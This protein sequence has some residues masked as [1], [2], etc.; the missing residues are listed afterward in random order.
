MKA[1]LVVASAQSSEIKTLMATA[2]SAGS[3][4]GL[5]ANYLTVVTPIIDKRTIAGRAN[6]YGVF[7]TLLFNPDNLEFVKTGTISIAA[8]QKTAN[9]CE[10]EDLPEECTIEMIRK[11]PTV[12]IIAGSSRTNGKSAYE[13]VK[14]W[15]EGKQIIAKLEQKRVV[16]IAFTTE[17]QP[18]MEGTRTRERWIFQP[19]KNE[20]IYKKVNDVLK[21]LYD[22]SQDE[23][24]KTH[25][26]AAGIDFPIAR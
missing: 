1:K 13:T 22:A 19:V 25:F 10:S 23:N 14:G 6:P 11:M 18:T 2:A 17:G 24:L 15:W 26:E 3:D 20:E 21:E 8:T 9:L 4:N 12:E 16:N 5:S 7:I